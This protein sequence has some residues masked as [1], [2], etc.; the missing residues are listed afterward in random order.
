MLG[1][2]KHGLS[3]LAN[4]TGRDARQTFWFY[5]LFVVILRFVA[6]MF[7][8]IPMMVKIMS[9]AIEAGKSGAQPETTQAQMMQNMADSM[10]GMAWYVVA[11]GVI[12][13]L[14]LAASLARRVQDSDLPGWLVL[15]PGGLYAAAIWHIPGQM[16][17]AADIMRHINP[18]NPTNPAAMMQGQMGYTL[19]TWIPLLLVVAA[20]VRPS[21][22]GPNRF[23]EAPASF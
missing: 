7:V 19:L 15:I 13:C 6:G 12:T 5:V 4:F 9:G 17:L 20:G 18:A 23:G 10:Q 21:S 14:L 3:N 22:D 8:S 16:A 2:I 11:I 1:A